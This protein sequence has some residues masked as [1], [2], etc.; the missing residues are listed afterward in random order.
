MSFYKYMA[1]RRNAFTVYHRYIGS[2]SAY[3]MAMEVVDRAN[4]D[5]RRDVGLR[6][7]IDFYHQYRDKYNL[8]LAEDSGDSCDFAGF[9]SGQ[10]VRIDVTTNVNFKK[11]AHY[12]KPSCAGREYILAVRT[13]TASSFQLLAAWQLGSVP[14]PCLSKEDAIPLV[15]IYPEGSS[16]G[17]SP[18]GWN[19]VKD[20]AYCHSCQQGHVLRSTDDFRIPTLSEYMGQVN[21]WLDTFSGL[22]GGREMQIEARNEN[23]KYL[24]SVYHFLKDYLGHEILAIGECQYIMTSTDGD[25]YYGIRI[26]KR[27]PCVESLLPN[28]IELD[29]LF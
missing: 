11:A 18:D 27:S 28:F 24:S 3:E 21:E 9:I 23:K 4:L 14:S 16:R 6:A 2:G 7:E 19:T 12:T 20:V 1:A 8:T 26:V 29:D 25:G 13:T 17:G 22:E 5:I 10:P 15:V